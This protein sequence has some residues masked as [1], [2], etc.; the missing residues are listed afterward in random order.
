MKQHPASSK[1][2]RKASINGQFLHYFTTRGLLLLLL[3]GYL[4]FLQFNHYWVTIEILLKSILGNLGAPHVQELLRIILV[5]FQILFSSMLVASIFLVLIDLFLRRFQFSIR[6]KLFD[7][8]KINPLDNLRARVT[9]G[10]QE[11]LKLILVI[12]LLIL[13]AIV[14]PINWNQSVAQTFIDFD[15][16]MGQVSLLIF[17]AFGLELLLRKKALLTAL[18]M[19]SEEVKNE[20]REEQ[21]DPLI[22]SR[23]QAE[24]RLLLLDSMEVKVRRSKVIFINK[25]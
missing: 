2:L 25:Y 15:D 19:D 18:S 14:I 11:I 16:L 17:L 8:R 13:F 10:K 24:Y 1:K 4:L 6:E 3:S 12:S 5:S 22:A 21:S 7:L 23:L 20:S 9:A